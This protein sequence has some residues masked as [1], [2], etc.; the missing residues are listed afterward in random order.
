MQQGYLYSGGSGLL[1]SI[2]WIVA[3]IRRRR[4]MMM[5]MMSTYDDKGPCDPNS[6]KAKQLL[7][8]TII[9]TI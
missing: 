5:P 1:L 8:I 3:L 9:N 4:M 7:L 2:K 6:D